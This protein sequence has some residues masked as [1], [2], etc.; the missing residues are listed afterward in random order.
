MNSKKKLQVFVSST[1]QDLRE[2]RQAA[3]E[4]ILTAGHIP[5]GME[6]FAA[7]DKSQMEVIQ[8]W[9]EESDVFLL[10]LGGRY[11]SIEPESQMSY[12][13]LEYEYAVSKNK[14][15]FAVV[16]G[17]QY[18]EEKIKRLGS[19]AVDDPVRLK[20]FRD[21]IEKK[22]VKF[23]NDPRDI[24]LAILETLM[25]FARRSDLHGWVPGNESMDTAAVAEEL[26]R[27]AREN[28]DLRKQLAD[29]SSAIQTYS[30]LRYDE[31]IRLLVD[32]KLDLTRPGNVADKEFTADVRKAARYA[33]RTSASLLDGFWV[34]RHSTSAR[35]EV[36]F[37]DQ[38]LHNTIE[39][40]EFYGLVQRIRED[41]YMT[42]AEYRLTPDGRRF[43]LRLTVET[44]LE[45]ARR[46]HPKDDAPA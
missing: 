2:E 17:E 9:I 37:D 18:L 22:I 8:R 23:W 43:L 24:K 26:A 41:K 10:I 6:L 11:G 19:A 5:A 39:R 27:L 14:P 20:K 38:N 21:Q 13:H 35:M 34:L 32:E 15:Y 45:K 3:V 33:K 31:L 30:G 25:E 42:T 4:A 28:A 29:G 12:I 40:L 36:E 7:G 16:I 1:Y 46:K 44:R